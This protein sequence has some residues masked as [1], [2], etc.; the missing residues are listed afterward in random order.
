M[1][2]CPLTSPPVDLRARREL[3]QGFGEALSRAFELA[4]TP[5]V[6][7]FF[8][9]LIDMRLGT[10]PIF[11]L[12]LALFAVVG[13]FVK[14]W[15]AYDGAMKARDAEAPWGRNNTDQKTGAK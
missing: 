12:V 14:L 8:G 10:S 2:G 11:M 7:G 13:S 5:V 15:Y 6:F 4:V 1:K 9:Y 3:N